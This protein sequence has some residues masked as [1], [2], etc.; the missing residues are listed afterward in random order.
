MQRSLK[1]LLAV[2]LLFTFTSAMV[3]AQRKPPV[4][5]AII[6]SLPSHQAGKHMVSQAARAGLSAQVIHSSR[7]PYLTPG[8]W[9]VT[10]GRST[11]LHQA[12]R[13]A[14]DARRRGFQGAYAKRA[15]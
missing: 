5:F 3:T 8:H 15:L 14:N 11:S 13:M 6:G 10:V 4:Y 7:Y 1:V 2:A 12:Q 9:V